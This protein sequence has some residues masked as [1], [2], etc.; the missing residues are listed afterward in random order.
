M[1]LERKR[2][3]KTLEIQRDMGTLAKF[4]QEWKGRVFRESERFEGMQRVPC[5]VEDRQRDLPNT[6]FLNSQN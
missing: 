6:R 4:E 1:N 3:I 2:M 5:H